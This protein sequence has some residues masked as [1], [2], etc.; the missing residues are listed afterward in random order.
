MFAYRPSPSDTYSWVSSTVFDRVSNKLVFL[1]KVHT[2]NACFVHLTTL[3]RGSTLTRYLNL[4][5]ETKGR[6]KKKT[7]KTAYSNTFSTA[8]SSRPNTLCSLLLLHDVVSEFDPSNASF[9]VASCNR[10]GCQTLWIGYQLATSHVPTSFVLNILL[11]KES[12]IT[13]VSSQLH[14]A[15]RPLWHWQQRACRIRPRNVMLWNGSS[16][17]SSSSSS[18]RRIGSNI[19]GKCFIVVTLRAHAQSWSRLGSQNRGL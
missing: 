15:I 7:R 1:P 14:S 12:F 19:I 9:Q 18:K 17:S 3:R 11:D 10:Q 2:I 6:K 4:R 16:S 5:Q 8:F 13:K